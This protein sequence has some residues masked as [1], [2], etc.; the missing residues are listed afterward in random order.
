MTD[1]WRPSANPATLRLRAAALARCRNFFAERQIMEVETPILTEFSVTEPQIASMSTCNNAG[2]LW[3]RTS[4]EYHMKRLLASG[5]PDIY[6]IARCF[7]DGERGSQHQPEFTLVEWYRHGFT[8]P[9]LH[10]ECCEL[11][12]AL[13]EP[14]SAGA[15]LPA[16]IYR[17]TDLFAEY[18]QVDPLTAGLVEFEQAARRH[19]DAASC[20]QLANSPGTRRE[21]WIDLLMS[22]V[23]QPA[24]PH[25]ELAIVV[26][27]P[28]EQA[29]LASLDPDNP[30]VAQRCE[31]FCNGLELA[32]GFVE[33]TDAAEQAGR[34]AAD[35][36]RRRNL[37]LPDMQSDPLLLAA[38]EAG[39]PPCA[40]IALGFDRTLMALTGSARLEQTLAF[41]PGR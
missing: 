31:I 35:R 30:K 36:D 11:I 25:G 6:Q 26:D 13:A 17:Y 28:A 39:L 34:F 37:G 4:P 22:L 27:Y 14:G 8:L 20:E 1:D 19:L 3:L 41:A 2:K 5:S 24:L 9:A 7:R 33:L 15:K 29:M 23:I 16:R 18:A 32:N 12:R 40:G 10:E 38:L 21:H